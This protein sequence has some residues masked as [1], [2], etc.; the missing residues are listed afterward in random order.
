MEP[1]WFLYDAPPNSLRDPKISS[2][3]KPQ[4]KKGVDAHS[5]IHNTFGVGGHVKALR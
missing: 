4:K 5:L 1:I 3:V 2:K